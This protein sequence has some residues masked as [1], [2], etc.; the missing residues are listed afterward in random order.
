MSGFKFIK[1]PKYQGKHFLLSP[2]SHRLDKDRTP[3]E[4]DKYLRADYAKDIGTAIHAL[5]AESIEYRIQAEP[6]A[7]YNDIL[8][9]L[10]RAGIPRTII[11]PYEFVDTYV[12]YVNDAILYDMTPEVP[13]VYS[14]RAG[15]TTDAIAY[16]P[17]KKFLRIHDLKTGSIPAKMDQLA[18]YAAYFCLCYKKKPGEMDF[19]LRIYQ[20][21]EAVIAH[22][23]A[24]YI[25]PI[26]DRIETA[27]NYLLKNYEE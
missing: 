19:E 23:D 13:L 3:E 2:S 8:R 25:L 1:D 21:G 9:C 11:D 17:R 12:L 14:S 26:M 20:S 15:G 5:A 4:L 18:E 22:P 16:N 24:D 7:A 27:S 6:K 10:L